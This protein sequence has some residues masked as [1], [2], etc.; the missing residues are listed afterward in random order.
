VS[1][2]PVV[3]K[4]GGTTIIEQEDVLREIVEE[5]QTRPLVVVHGAA[6]G[7]P[8]GS[9]DWA[10]RATGTTVAASPTKLRWRSSWRSS[11]ASSTPS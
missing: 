1:A 10:S 4:L 8:T 5:R 2:T 6:S 11:V 9:S 7:S 3:V